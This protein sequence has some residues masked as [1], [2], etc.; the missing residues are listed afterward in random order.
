M[1]SREKDRHEYERHDSRYEKDNRH[2]QNGVER[3]TTTGVLD[4]EIIE[5][6]Q[7]RKEEEERRETERRQA[8]AKKLQA[9]E[10][11]IQSK[12][13]VQPGEEEAIP[14]PEN[15]YN[16]R[17]G[18]DS[19][20][21]YSGR[22]VRNEKEGYG[23][24]RYE[25][26]DRDN[27]G[28]RDKD[29][30]GR[31]DRND[32]ND[33]T[34]R[35]DRNVD[36]RD[37][38]Y[39]PNLPPRFQRQ[40]Q[41]TSSPINRSDSQNER[42]DS[43]R[44]NRNNNFDRGNPSASSTGFQGLPNTGPKSQDSYSSA[45]DSD[46]KNI[47]FAQ[48]YDPRYIHQNLNKQLQQQAN[49]KRSD[50]GNQSNRG[51]HRDARV[52]SSNRRRIDS[53]DDD[54]FSSGRDSLGRSNQVSMRKTSVS[55]DDK[56]TNISFEHNSDAREKIS[57]WVDE[58]EN[59][60]KMEKADGYTEKQRQLMKSFDSA[61]IDS[62]PKQILQR[63]KTS[64]SDDA[65]TP[66]N[67]S[68]KSQDEKSKDGHE[69]RISESPKSWADSV[70]N[71]EENTRGTDR[72][73]TDDTEQG[74]DQK[75][76]SIKGDSG[77]KV[78]N[79]N[80]GYGDDRRPDKNQRSRGGGDRGGRYDSRSNRGGGYTSYR[81]N[82][83]SNWN[84]RGRGGSHMGHHRD[85]YYSESDGSD[86]EMEYD[87][88]RNDGRKSGKDAPT[89]KYSS[90]QNREGFTP[91]G[92]PSR[93]GRGSGGGVGQYSRRGTSNSNKRYDNYGSSGGKGVADD[94][95]PDDKDEDR[96]PSDHGT[97]DENTKSRY[98]KQGFESQRS[99]NNLKNKETSS[100]DKKE[101]AEFKHQERK[102]ET[103]PTGDSKEKEKSPEAEKGSDLSRHDSDYRKASGNNRK[104]DND[105]S[106][107]SQYQR[108]NMSNR[109][110][111]RDERDRGYK[112]LSKPPGLSGKPSQQSNNPHSGGRIKTNSTS[113]IGSNSERDNR[114]PRSSGKE[115]PPSR[116]VSKSTAPNTKSGNQ[117]SSIGQWEKRSSSGSLH[118]DGQTHPE[119]IEEGTNPI[120]SVFI[121]FSIILFPF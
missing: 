50:D 68:T 100:E 87:S 53:E 73:K 36:P 11:K 38:N 3:R 25:K 115:A 40:H 83:S 62:E 102:H 39:Q 67:T 94:E 56:P 92:E 117:N 88:R 4:K 119:K 95:K 72:K 79:E 7:L 15:D 45:T 82:S 84:R 13:T 21:N 37:R 2:S 112:P 76:K 85:N 23:R 104:D 54:R 57:S 99:N 43:E 32:R 74:S 75:M 97:S 46:T 93:R 58:L 121:I 86:Y 19:N 55:S 89:N 77:S 80:R 48:Q 35:N 49:R 109:N 26:Y 118:Q 64:V 31:N 105:R 24:D 101:N 110:K 59:E 103:K 12:R 20:R 51:Q 81:G 16:K 47:P 52:E 8:A 60:S 70:T 63:S 41:S 66:V 91:R 42:G 107:G 114:G 106:Y 65:S 120:P 61:S 78:S 1:W 33:R 96:K 14:K 29:N 111:T 44:R 27:Y 18:N 113:S 69:K 90:S 5:R 34:D 17:S 71:A 6:V 30:Y 22:E 10:Q 28:A 108:S 98:S 9:L 116:T